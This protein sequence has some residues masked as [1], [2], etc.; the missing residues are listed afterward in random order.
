MADIRFSYQALTAGSH[1][2]GVAGDFSAWE[3]LDLTDIGGFYVLNL[4]IEPGI[5]RYKLIVD[6]VWMQDPANPEFEPDPF[7]G[8]NSV[9]II[10]SEKVKTP[11][12]AEIYADLSL[13]DDRIER[14]IDIHRFDKHGFELR[15]AWYPSIPAEISMRFDDADIP[16][17]RVGTVSNRDVHHGVFHDAAE[18]LEFDI[19][20]KH[21]GE[22]LYYG[23]NGFT[24]EPGSSLPFYIRLDRHEIFSVPDWVRKGIIYQIFPDRFFNGDP[25]INPDFNEWYYDDCRT[26]PPNGEIL[27]PQQE[28]YHLVEDWKDIRGL[29][30]SPWLEE[31]KPDWWSFYGGDLRGVI[32][33]LDYLSELGISIIYFNPLWEAKSNHKYD[34]ADYR[35]IDAH[36]GS[37]ADMIELVKAARKRGIRVILDVAFNHTGE[38]FWAFRDGV[39]NGD[40]SRYWDWYDWQKWPLPKPLPPDFKPRDYYQCWWGIKD[41]PDLNYDLSRKHPAE[42]YVHDIKKAIPNAPLVNYILD[43]VTWWL[44][45]IGIDGFRLDVPDEVPFWFWEL[46][47]RH[48]KSIKPDAWLVGEIWHNA[49]GWVNER[50]F[51]SVMN[52]AYFKNPVLEFFIFGIIG[53]QRFKALIEEGLARYPFHASGAMMNLLGSHDTWRILELAEGNIA[54]LKLALIFQ[55]TFVGAPH[56]YYGDEIGMMGRK[57]PDNRRPFDWDWQGD[58]RSSDLRV[59][60]KRMIDLR[61]DECLLIDGEFRFVETEEGILGYERFDGESAIRVFINHG[62]SPV[63]IS[64]REKGDILFAH[65]AEITSERAIALK[66]HAAVVIKYLKER[67]LL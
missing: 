61:K 66:P 27:A 24:K 12:W 20:L 33:K 35:R 30:Q 65:N 51:D 3:I 21:G 26:P 14:F 57:D 40:D 34:A 29:S 67:R 13:L 56:I 62:L 43:S 19:I 44:K 46:F 8:F 52:Y 54:K 10:E 45:D 55:M 4:H 2:V 17:I 18:E 5:Y 50:Y 1:E 59:F 42:N 49:Q 36:F 28:Y 15:F 60:Y 31:G 64:F 37:T 22:I 23:K 7:G 39:E 63:S 11:S 53:S 58:S 9:I 47:R 41:M 25:R 48:V 32:T 16:L 6:G 38:T